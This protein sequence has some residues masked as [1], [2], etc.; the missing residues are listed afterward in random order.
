MLLVNLNVDSAAPLQ[1]ARGDLGVEI[2]V[3]KVALA[4]K[5]MISKCNLAGKQATETKKKTPNLNFESRSIQDTASQQST[6]NTLCLARRI[7]NTRP[8][9]RN[10]KT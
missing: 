8:E 9:T 6:A 2:P 1:V 4:Q 10:P 7:A 5:M 3:E